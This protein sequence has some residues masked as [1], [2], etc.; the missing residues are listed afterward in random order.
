M[1]AAPIVEFTDVMKRYGSPEPLRISSL[2]LEAGER[3]ALEGL[4]D[5]SAE[6]LV[7][8][9]TGAAVP[10]AGRVSIEGRDT[11]DIGT[12]T[13][14]LHLLDRLGLVSH[15]AVLI[16]PIPVAANMALPLTLAIDPMSDETRK[17]VEALA[18]E[19]DLPRDRLAVPA[20]MLEPPE[21]LRLH[22]GRALALSPHL[23][24]MEHPTTA[25]DRP[26]SERLGRVLR[27]IADRRG[28]ALL[29]VGQNPP[30]ARAA[31]ARR[32]SLDARTGHLSDVGLW[33]RLVG[34]TFR[35]LRT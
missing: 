24:V 28:L 4:D 26:A 20:S 11:R 17:Q 21:R 35:K 31:A 27:A 2:R 29:I 14:W 34:P 16:E 3:A 23:L 30:L 8:L 18:A 13:D 5:Q 22:L 32:L 25:L 7:H 6:M 9:L 12:D 15:R 33:N 19:V 10:D 1:P